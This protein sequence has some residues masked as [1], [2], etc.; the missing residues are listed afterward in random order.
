MARFNGGGNRTAA[1]NGNFTAER[2][3]QIEQLF[4]QAIDRDPPDRAAFLAGAC[5]GDEALLAEINKLLQSHRTAGNF[6]EP[7][8]DAIDPSHGRGGPDLPAGQRI[9]SFTI[10]RVIGHGG[11]GTVYEAVQDRPRRTVALKVLKFG[12]SITQALRRFELELQVLARLRHPA[13][14]QIYEAGTF[15]GDG[16]TVPY[17]AL[18]YIPDAKTIIDYAESARLGTRRRLQLFAE[19]C[20]AVHHG[21]QK[22]IIHRD[23]KPYNILVD[24]AGQL[25]VIDFGIARATDSDVAATTETD[26]GQ[27]IGTLPYMSPEQCAADPNE[28][29]I[30]SDVYALGVVLYELVCGQLPYAVRDKPIT[31]VVRTIQEAKPRRPSSDNAALGGD[32][33]TIILKTLDK[34]RDQRYQSAAEL[35]ADIR[36]YLTRQPILARPPSWS[37]HFRLFARRNMVL[38]LAAAGSIAVLIAA[39]VISMTYAWRATQAVQGETE[40]RSKAERISAFLQDTLT[41]ASPQ[42][43]QGD[44][45]VLGMLERAARRIEVELKD[46]PEIEAGVRL[47][48][49][50]TYN[51][52]WLWGDAQPHLWV[53]L[54]LLRDLHGNEHPRVAE[55]LAALTE[56]LTRLHNRNGERVA[57]DSL[58]LHK[59]L[60]GPHSP[61]VTHAM[62][63]LAFA[64]ARCPQPPKFQEAEEL[65]TEAMARY[66]QEGGQDSVDLAR[67]KHFLASMRYDQR[68]YEEAEALY[69]QILPV[70]QE[71]LGKDDVLVS[72]CLDDYAGVL[73][74]LGRYRES[75]EL[76]TNAMKLSPSLLGGHWTSFMRFRR[77][78]ML[79]HANREYDAAERS[80]RQS[81]ARFCESQATSAPSGA[82]RFNELAELLRRPAPHREVRPHYRHVFQALSAHN[83]ALYSNPFAASLMAN[84]A[85]LLLDVREYELARGMLRDAARIVG[86]AIQNGQLGSDHWL[87]ADIQ[88]GIAACLAQRGDYERSELFMV[89]SYDRIEAGLGADHWRTALVLERLIRFYDDWGKPEVADEYREKRRLESTHRNKPPDDTPLLRI[90]SGRS[91]VVQ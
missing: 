71:Q 52:L 86:A 63:D 26:M 80:F 42:L 68:R 51:S 90:P 24:V 30:R 60:Y 41:S 36:R 85:D 47:A 43:R 37:Y 27:L 58:A 3:A 88:S 81:L 29:D 84:V 11:G 32:I 21:H 61:Q 91:A 67:C 53:A 22:G 66:T 1:H 70:Y 64:L 31:Q 38:V 4:H 20:D 82:E 19:V 28:I 62:R 48:I 7:P 33:E 75:E 9:G 46:Q 56:S 17:F 18:E 14:A 40:Q 54:H 74:A 23:L 12:R 77:M 35:A 16:E 6:I 50:K 89:R 45:S 13:I 83:P 8:T 79:Q 55:C 2:L 73:H 57:R 69:L 49:G 44:A 25:K 65:F 10:V 87:R 76:L 5:T 59:Q 72:E 15:Q 78:A 34:D 39:S